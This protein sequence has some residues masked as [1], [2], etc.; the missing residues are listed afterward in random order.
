M[1]QNVGHAA[2]CV[3]KTL[4]EEYGTDAHSMYHVKATTATMYLGAHLLS[5]IPRET[6]DKFD[7]TWYLGGAETVCAL[8]FCASPR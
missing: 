5:F 1:R 7:S 4:V 2:D 3:A 6:I 8:I